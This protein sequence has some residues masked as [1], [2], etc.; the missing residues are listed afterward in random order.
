MKFYIIDDDPTITMI[1]QD[2]IEEDFNNT[3]V[4]VNNVSS[5]AYNE[6]L[7]ADVDIVLIDLLMPILDG[8]T[9]VQKI[10]KQRSDLKFIMIS[11]VKDNDLRQEAYKAGIEFFIN[12]PINIIEV[13]SVVKRVTDTIEMQKKLNTIQN[14]LENTP[15]YQKPITTSN[16][17]KIRS[18]LSYLGITSETAYTDILNICELLLKQELNFAQFDFQKELSIDEHQQKIIL[19]RIRRA[20]KKAMINMAHLYID[21]FENELT[22]QY[23]NA[24]FGF[25]NIHNEAQLIQGK[26]M[27]GGKISLKHFFNELILQS[28]TF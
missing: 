18:I 15:S 21:D 26:S 17:T 4:R 11:Q 12:K 10:Y 7:I 1:L 27:Y 14:L 25:Q 23:A 13:K 2:I 3:V 8:V 28:K 24:L 16:L 19:Q 9:L 22:L 20:V 5:K 6:L